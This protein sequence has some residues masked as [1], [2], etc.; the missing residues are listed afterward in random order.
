MAGLFLLKSKGG[1]DG[2]GNKTVN[3][4]TEAIKAFEKLGGLDGHDIFAAAF[5]DFTHE[6]A[7]QAAAKTRPVQWFIS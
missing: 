4:Y 1:Y 5:V 6:L 2:Y 7:V 3:N